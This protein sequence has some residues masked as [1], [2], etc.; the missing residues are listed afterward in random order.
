MSEGVKEAAARHW[1]GVRPDDLPRRFWQ[2][3]GCIRAINAVMG[4]EGSGWAEGLMAQM[5]RRL[6]GRRL[7]RGLS[8]GCGPGSKEL[9]LVQAGIVE[10][11][12]LYE[13]SAV[14]VVQGRAL[15]QGRGL[16]DRGRFLSGDGLAAL[17]DPAG[18]DLVY[19]DNALHHMPR[20]AE[21]LRRSLRA[22]RPGGMLAVY[23]F[24]GPDR[25]QWSDEELTWAR[26]VRGALPPRFFDPAAGARLAAGRGVARP[27]VEA[28]LALDP[29]EAMDSA[30]ILPELR[31][32]APADAVWLL[33][34]VV[35]A[36]ALNDV[37]A[38]FRL[39]EDAALLDSLML[40]DRALA[41]QGLNHYAAALVQRPA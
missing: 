31:R 22:L 4:A 16:A 19:W 7:A 23:E 25:F 37:L 5:R 24:V 18:Y 11:F 28:M 17:D 10:G 38:N 32:L 6:G 14:R 9:A 39:P 36:L 29:S 2:V 21:V 12:D 26:R 34:G 3:A 13:I 41:G 40:L 30:A 27:T 35:Y 1:D 20:T 8:V 33:G 15:W